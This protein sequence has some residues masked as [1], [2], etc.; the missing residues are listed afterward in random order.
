MTEPLPSP[1]DAIDI[2]NTVRT[3]F[4]DNFIQK[5]M[6][7]DGDGL[8]V[9]LEQSYGLA[10]EHRIKHRSWIL[11]FVWKFLQEKSQHY[12]GR[13]TRT[14]SPQGARDPE[15]R[16]RTPSSTS[17]HSHSIS[18]PPPTPSAIHLEHAQSPMTQPPPSTHPTSFEDE[19]EQA[20]EIRSSE[21]GPAE[22]QA[23]DSSELEK[24]VSPGKLNELNG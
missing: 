6:N 13:G 2:S 22:H 24:L 1:Y 21:T 15:S 4:K 10:R 19:S 9:G 7:V 18:R 17:S 16:P 11:H 12:R 20:L 14:S 5:Y 3:A 23:V 8:L